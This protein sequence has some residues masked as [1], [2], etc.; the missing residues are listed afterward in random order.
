MFVDVFKTCGFKITLSVIILGVSGAVARPANPSVQKHTQSDG[1][2]LSVRSFGDEHYHYKVTGDGLLVVPDATGDYV[3]VGNDGLRSGVKAKDPALRDSAERAFVA[4]IDQERALALHKNLNTDRFPSQDRGLGFS[5]NPRYTYDATGTSF[6]KRMR[7]K[8]E[9][10]VTGERRFPVLLVSTPGLAAVDSLRVWRYFNEEGYSDNEG[11]VGSV[12]DYYLE[13]SNGLFSPHFDIFPVTLS[14]NLTQYVKGDSLAE[15]EITKEGVELMVKRA[16]FDGSKYCSS[17]KVVDGF[18]FMFP[19]R[20]Q[21]VLGYSEDFWA[22]QFWMQANGANNRWRDPYGYEASNKYIFDKYVFASQLEDDDGWPQKTCPNGACLNKMGIFIHEF[23]HVL[24]LPDHYGEDESGNQVL[25]PGAYDLMSAGM[26]N[27]TGRIPA[28]FSAF[29]REMMGWMKLTELSQ[30]TDVMQLA[31]IDHGQAYSVTNPS[32]NDEYFIVE[33]RPAKGYDAAITRGQDYAYNG[34]WIWYIKYE[35][36]AW[37][38][39]NVNGMDNFNRVVVKTALL[40]GSRQSKKSYS[41]FTYKSGR[42]ASIPGVYNFMN[43]GDSLV[44]FSVDESVSVTQCNPPSSSSVSSSS[45]AE[46]SSSVVPPSSSAMSSAV[47]SS[48]SVAPSSSSVVLPE[49]SSSVNV[50]PGSSSVVGLGRS[51]ASVPCGLVLEGRKLSVTASWH[52]HKDLRLFDMQGNTVYG[53]GFAGDAASLDLSRL[54]SGTYVARV[55]APG[56]APVTRVLHIK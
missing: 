12:R 56:Y 32:D 25:G 15:N 44:C 50:E 46:S 6:V 37:L 23:A 42:T 8:G 19:G 49:S 43:S 54:T 13:S 33:Y 40:T 1:S 52:G 24:G 9:S 41:P 18:I 35:E 36:E 38:M 7:P 11:N 2:V 48:S 28:K 17:G 31:D 29:E 10:W 47:V 20:E 55:T 14:K 30:G 45:V 3:Y 16:D 21:D 5:H 39:N 26:Y 34:V 22:H 4:G 27:E 53:A 51:L